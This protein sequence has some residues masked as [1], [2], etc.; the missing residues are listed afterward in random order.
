M[1]TLNLKVRLYII[2]AIDWSLLLLILGIGLPA[3]FYSEHRPL[4]AAGV[5]AGLA[6]VDWIG[7]WSLNRI[8]QLQYTLD[9]AQKNN[10]L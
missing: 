1:S 9:R 8:A 4:Y 2:K 6:L 10:T 3:I 5:I 7:R